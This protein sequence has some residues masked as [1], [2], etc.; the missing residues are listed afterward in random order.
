M[1]VRIYDIARKLGL[2]SKVVL[3]KA[4]ELGITHVKVASS[5]LDK[6]T[7]EFLEDSL[8]HP[9]PAATAATE[10]HP[11]AEAGQAGHATPAGSAQAE[12]EAGS[13]PA[14]APA[15]V[16]ATA[17]TPT[18]VEAA[19]TPTPA[20]SPVHAD[21]PAPA[22]S[23]TTE[24]VAVAVEA[25]S[26]EKREEARSH[27]PVAVP[28]AAPE[29]PTPNSLPASSAVVSESAESAA[30]VAAPAPVVAAEPVS[31][32]ALVPSPTAPVQP[33]AE[34]APVAEDVPAKPV[35][36][37]APANLKEPAQESPPV[38]SVVPDMAA[39]VP[40]VPAQPPAAAVPTPPAPQ[41]VKTPAIGELVGRIE[42]PFRGRPGARSA[43][44]PPP[45]PPPPPARRIEPQRG[46]PPGGQPYQQPRGTGLQGGGPTRYGS[47]GGQQ[48][49]ST[50]PPP[51]PPKPPGGAGK[52]AVLPD[53]IPPAQGKIISLKPPIIVRDL[54]EKVGVKA[55]KILHDLMELGVFANLN[56]AVDEKVAGFLA[57]RYGFR[58]EVERREKGAGQ[59]H[60]PVR[61]VEVDL[62]DKLEDLKPR[63]PVITIMG[64]VDHGKTTLLDVIRKSDVAAR[65]AGGITQHIGAYT[66]MVPHPERTKEL[67]Q[68]TFLDTPGHAAFSAMR[69]RGAN[70]TDIVILVVAASEGVMPQTVEALNHAKAAKVPIM[71]AVTKCDLPAANPLRVRQ[72][73]QEHGLVAEEWGGETIFVDVSAQ[74]K[75]GIDQLLSMLVLQSEV[76]ELKANYKRRAKGNVVESGLEPGGPTATVL[77]RK[78]T[79]KLGDIIIC[80]EYYGRTRALINEEGQ[81]LKEAGP[82]VAVKVLGLNGVPEAG[83]EFSVV[84]NERT[85]R[86][87]AE[88]REQQN[89][90]A[91]RERGP[92]VTLENLLSVIE[93]QSAKVLKVVV[94][95]DTQG[96]VE[97][98]VEALMKIES[99]KVSLE[100]VH[101]AVGT[102]TE[103]DVLLAAS[104]KGIIFG[105][106]TRQ[107]NGVPAAAK[108]EGVQIK[109]YEIIYELIDEVRSAMAG[110]LDPELKEVTIGSAEV[111]QIFD[112]SK[113]GRVAGCM[114]QNGRIVKGKA[115]IVRRKEVIHD[116]ILQTLRRY[117]DEVA[118][119]RS[120][121]ECGIRVSSFEEIQAGDIIEAYTVEKVAQQL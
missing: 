36:G 13:S 101:S 94:K 8:P 117:Q 87:M 102:I 104:C 55:Y 29:A 33:P 89:K 66:I 58:F 98:I 63:P 64:H 35:M 10:A 21:A 90:I 59:V 17:P 32:P 108:R 83:L 70:V 42:L 115:R 92:R 56:Q 31:A 93:Q 71:V 25:P 96:S 85:A 4:K 16:P 14:A 45:P 75:K 54:A 7:A 84:E 69:A 52:S 6:I 15:P 18:V 39:A 111:R 2:E 72:Q 26:H 114:V 121:L 77:V 109:Q 68:L 5:T 28:A 53:Y 3:A 19:P 62:E 79:L 88:E 112:L 22:V 120:G 78:G 65:E 110:L 99:T 80:G 95:G 51:P 47:Q 103:S 73:L 20:L 82:S 118:E 23:S 40:A 38:A 11:P 61:K 67:Q 97:A 100:I 48:R 41:A 74:A 49:F 27:E 50:P 76:L 24:P 106:H 34:A 43:P 113:G 81:R 57:A 107:D 91:G 105:F 86:D 116:G 9:A 12:S 46:R 60:A 37:E 1:P 119:V 30:P 44:T